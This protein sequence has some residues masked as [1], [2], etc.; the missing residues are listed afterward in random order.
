MGF[1]S[2]A[3]PGQITGIQAGSGLLSS[4]VN[5]LWA[6]AQMK[7]QREHQQRLTD[8]QY[9]KDLQ[10]WNMANAYNDPSAQ[11]KRL[12]DAGINPFNVFGGGNVSGNT[13]PASMPKYQAFNP[14][15]AQMN[16]QAPN[17]LDALQTYQ[18][19]KNAQAQYD[20]TQKQIQIADQTI[21]EKS[22][23][24]KYLDSMLIERYNTMKINNLWNP[25][26]Y[27]QEAERRYLDNSLKY[28]LYNTPQWL[29]DPQSRQFGKA[30]LDSP[31]FKQYQAGTQL[32]IAESRMKE[33]ET[34]LMEKGIYKH[35][36]P[37]LRMLIQSGGFDM[38]KE[39]LKSRIY[40]K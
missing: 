29:G 8:Y 10:M 36:N 25:L 16:I 30:S 11:M 24:N 17:I 23:N 12:K 34:K 22:T 40:G 28:M 14:E 19:I 32:R 5:N 31:Y 20:L 4:V 33:L 18:V 6:G 21:K 38:I 15:Y 1:L 7:K 37:V 9:A 27:D 13:V 3:S 39:F 26:K 35:D 2:D